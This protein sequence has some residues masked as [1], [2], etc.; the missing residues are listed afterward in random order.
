MVLVIMC[1]LSVIIPVYN[2]EVY[3][4]K[5]LDSIARQSY[6]D[7]EVIIIDDGSTDHSSQIISRYIR[8]DSRFF[9]FQQVNRG[10]SAARNTGLKMARGEYITFVDPDDWIDKDMYSIMLKGAFQDNY[11][12]IICNWFVANEDGT[13]SKH[14][15]SGQIDI[16]SNCDLLTEIKK[17]GACVWNKIFRAALINEWFPEEISIGEDWLFLASYCKNDIYTLYI[18]MPLYYYRSRA[19][20]AMNNVDN[21]RFLSVIANRKIVDISKEISKKCYYII[22]SDFIDRCCRFIILLSNEKEHEYYNLVHDIFCDYVKKHILNII[23]NPEIGVKQKIMYISL[24][25]SEYLE[26]HKR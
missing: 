17:I 26:H 6:N 9:L 18:D 13:I 23:C 5:C 1:K 25:R 22:E 8:S 3:I 16:R 15:I 4:E 11:D 19:D 24:F 2:V 7:F 21:K 10:V 20:S 12:I 14:L